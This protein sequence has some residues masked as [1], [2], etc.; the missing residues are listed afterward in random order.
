MTGEDVRNIL[1]RKIKILRNQKQYSQAQLSELADVSIPFLSAIERG[2]KW[3]YPETLAKIAVALDVQI[4]ELFLEDEN[5]KDENSAV[6]SI[7]RELVE[8]QQT[9]LNGLCD[10]YLK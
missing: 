9:L 1:A 8:G 2:T 3:P 10:K 5:I 4:Y 7:I 6:I